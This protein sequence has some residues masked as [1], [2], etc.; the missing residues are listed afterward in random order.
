[1][2]YD[3]VPKKTTC[4]LL[5]EL[6]VSLPPETS[7][8]YKYFYSMFL[9]EVLERKLQQEELSKNRLVKEVQ[10]IHEVRGSFA[11]KSC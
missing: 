9:K 11:F 10:D 4:C 5:D 7:Y 3:M 2:F 1:M 6:K 8:L